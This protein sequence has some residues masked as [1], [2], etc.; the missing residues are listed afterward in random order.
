MSQNAPSVDYPVGRFFWNAYWVL[1]L[2]VLSLLA[3]ILSWLAGQ[4]DGWRAAS[5]FAAWFFL[6]LFSVASLKREATPHWLCWDGQEWL[7][8]SALSQSTQALALAPMPAL[9]IRLD[10]PS[11]D[12]PSQDAYAIRVHLDF[13]QYLFVSLF[14]STSRTQWFWVAKRSFPERWH[15]FRCAVYSHSD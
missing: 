9:K 11:I 1:G 2:A 7:V 3:L 8:Q 6:T 10:R 15:G 4:F 14:N 12:L 13:Q 5:L